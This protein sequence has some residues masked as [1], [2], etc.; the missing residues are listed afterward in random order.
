MSDSNNAIYYVEKTTFSVIISL[1]VGEISGTCP[2]AS[3]DIFTLNPPPDVLALS[4]L[5]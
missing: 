1:I 4:F 3:G 2:Q 5:P